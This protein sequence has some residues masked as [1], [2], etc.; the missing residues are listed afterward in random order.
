MPL[1]TQMGLQTEFAI[2][3][4]GVKFVYFWGFQKFT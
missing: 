3:V 1:L 2:P 4:N